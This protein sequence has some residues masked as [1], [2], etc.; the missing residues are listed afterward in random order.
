M[1]RETRLIDPLSEVTR[2][3]RKVLLGLSVLSIFI[4]GTDAVPTKISALGI[5]F[6]AMDQ[7][8]F[9]WLLAAVIAYFTI[10]F[11]VYASSD[12]VAWKKEML[13]EYLEGLKEYW[14]DVYEAPT[15]GNP[16]LDAIEHDRQIA[17]RKHRLIYRMTNPISVVRAFFEFLLP[18]LV[19]G[20]TFYIV[21]L[22]C[23]LST[24]LRHL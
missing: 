3:E 1:A 14:S 11:I 18:V 17:F 8:V 10:T 6:G 16:Y 7:Q 4:V 24:L 23:E 15:S 9:V 12:Y 22:Q 13:D 2:K 20:A 21:A 19:G 5:E